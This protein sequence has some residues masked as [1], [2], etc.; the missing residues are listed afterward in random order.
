MCCCCRRWHY[1]HPAHPVLQYG[2]IAGGLADGSVCVWNPARIIGHKAEAAVPASPAA[3][4][5]QLLARL[6]KHQGAVK[7]LEFNG[8]RCGCCCCCCGAVA[9]G[10]AA[11]LLLLLVHGCGIG[12]GWGCRWGCG[13]CGCWPR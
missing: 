11:L 10:G 7:G 5:G 3:T 8:F 1:K 6:Q 4:C 12:W 2:L 9:G 13:C